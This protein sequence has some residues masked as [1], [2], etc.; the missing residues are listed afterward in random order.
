MSGDLNLVTLAANQ[1]GK[2]DTVNEIAAQLE[3]AIAARVEIDVSAGDAAV[4]D[5]QMRRAAVVVATGATMARAVTLGAVA[6]VLTVVNASGTVVTFARGTSS[7]ALPAGGA[8]MIVTDGTANG[9]K[10]AGTAGVATFLGLED[11]PDAYTGAEGKVVAVKND[12]S[13]LEFVTPTSGGGG[14]ALPLGGTTGQVLAKVSNVDGDAGWIDAPSGG[15]A[16]GARRYWM[17]A[18]MTSSG[19]NPSIAE[20]HFRETAGGSNLTISAA[21]AKDSYDTGSSPAKAYDGNA[22]TFWASTSAPNFYYV[23][24]GSAHPVREIVI[25]ARND[26]W[27]QQRPT[28]FAVM[29]S[30]DAIQWKR[31][32]TYLYPQ[33]TTSGASITVSVPAG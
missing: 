32:V 8:A 15:G 13:G 16:V 17:L 9:L 26:G 23:D 1:T 30:D 14:G 6:R 21:V 4:T 12:A 7:L 10:V 33:E 5:E 11:A 24:L 27:H 25:T 31:L 28:S 29:Y 18:D 3:A 2:E 20:I 22:G 19:G